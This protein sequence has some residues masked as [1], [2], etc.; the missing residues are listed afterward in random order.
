MAAQVRVAV[1]EREL[2]NHDLQAR[3]ATRAKEVMA[4]KFTN[5]ELYDWMVGQVSGLYFR[6]YQLAYDL[7]KR[8]ER[9]YRYE[10]G[11][12]E[13]SFVQLRV[14]GQP[15]QGAAGRR[16]PHARGQAHGGEPGSTSTT[17]TSS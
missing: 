10:L 15:A 9:A 16:A 3:N 6:A 14:L 1:A 12:Q 5:R 13:S 11:V 17:A 2:A 4:D 8:A 7:A